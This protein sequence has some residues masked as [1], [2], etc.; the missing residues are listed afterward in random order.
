MWGCCQVRCCGKNR[1][2]SC[3]KHKCGVGHGGEAWV[4]CEVGRERHEGCVILMG[5]CDMRHKGACGLT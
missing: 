5:W 4:A 3:D 1:V 2:N